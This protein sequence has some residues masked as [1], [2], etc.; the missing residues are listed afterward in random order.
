MK[1]KI[2]YCIW[3]GLFILCALLGF[4][5]EPEG[6]LYAVLLIT[7]ILFF[8][9]GGL[10]LYR[11]YQSKDIATMVTIR[12]ISLISLAATLIFLVLNFLTANA[13][14]AAGDLLY[15]FLVI[16]SS[17]MVCSQNWLISLFLWACLLMTSISLQKQSKK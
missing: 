3:G 17:P 11:A 7:S 15:G 4:I 1:N 16:F 13:T 5:P 2:L 12:A 6:F 10:L 14:K 8:V 9:P